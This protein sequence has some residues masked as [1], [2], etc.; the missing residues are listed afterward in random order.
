MDITYYLS[1]NQRK[2]LLTR[3]RRLRLAIPVPLDDCD[4]EEFAS[5]VL[6]SEL[7][8]LVS[9]VE[10]REVRVNPC[11]GK[12]DTSLAGL[13]GQIVPDDYRG[14]PLFSVQI[15]VVVVTLTPPRCRGS[16]PGIH[17]PGRVHFF[18]LDIP[19]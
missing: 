14:T 1:N 2:E 8:D 17:W 9:E 3:G 18:G 12:T 10:D 16:V 5:K 13:L 11:A 7:S 15:A 4:L 6:D 19:K